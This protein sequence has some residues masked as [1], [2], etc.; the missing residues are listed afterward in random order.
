MIYFYYNDLIQ[1]SNQ[2]INEEEQIENQYSADLNNFI[3]SLDKKNGYEF[4]KLV[5]IFRSENIDYS[6]VEGYDCESTDAMICNFEKIVFNIDN[7][8]DEL[9]DKYD[10]N[11]IFNITKDNNKYTFIILKN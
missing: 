4:N 5:N 9:I 7:A 6:V 8:I 11:G 2:V 3:E 10:L 1:P